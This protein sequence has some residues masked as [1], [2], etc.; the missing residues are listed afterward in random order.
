MTIAERLRRWRNQ[1]GPGPDEGEPTMGAFAASRPVWTAADHRFEGELARRLGSLYLG[2]TGQGYANRY[3]GGFV[4]R[5]A[6]R[7]PTVYVSHHSAGSQR[8]TGAELWRYHVQTRGWSTDGYHIVVRP[9]GR[10]ELVIPPSM[11]SYGAAQFN[12]HTVHVCCPGNYVSQI[13]A[14]AMLASLY[15]VFL[16]L[17]VC[18]GDHQWKAHRELPMATACNGGLQP[19]LV[20]MRGLE[21]GAAS[22]PKERYP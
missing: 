10:V 14:P 15:Q 9:D 1:D 11:M 12:P 17:D 5:P 2:F 8:D 7:V 21:Y 20:R 4:S 16:A 22:P 18:Y 19:H 6:G 3:G 13:P